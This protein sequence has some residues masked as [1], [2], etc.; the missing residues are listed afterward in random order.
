MHS[1]AQS[2]AFLLLETEEHPQ[3]DH[4]PCV[5][6]QLPDACLVATSSPVSAALSLRAQ[7]SA[8]LVFSSLWSVCLGAEWPGHAVALSHFEEVSDCFLEEPRHLPSPSA[9]SPHPHRRLSVSLIPATLVP[10]KWRLTAALICVR[11]P[12]G[13]GP[14]GTIPLLIASFIRLWRWM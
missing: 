13:Q 9:M 4:A 7:A 5:H 1:A 11:V 12:D 10:A 2:K 3:W 8:G 14:G 6:Q